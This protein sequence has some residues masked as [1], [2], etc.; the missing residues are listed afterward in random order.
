MSCKERLV[1]YF[2]ITEKNPEA[3]TM[4]PSSSTGD[5]SPDNSYSP[6]LQV[7]KQLPDVV[8]K[9]KFYSDNIHQINAKVITDLKDEVL[10][11]AQMCEGTTPPLE[12]C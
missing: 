2:R 12:Y 6:L 5:P 10:G 9:I 8:A 11:A 1:R 3:E 7:R 4:D